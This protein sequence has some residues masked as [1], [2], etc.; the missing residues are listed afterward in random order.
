MLFFILIANNGITRFYTYDTEVGGIMEIMLRLYCIGL[1]ADAGSN[2]LAFALRALGN[3]T[4]VFKSYCIAFYLIAI[5]GCLVLSIVADYGFYGI[6][7]G[8]IAGYWAM[9]IFMSFK[10]WKLDWYESMKIV[11]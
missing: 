3:E 6:W 1:M 11:H 2:T 4:Y 8:L 9:M 7:S 10:L 5:P